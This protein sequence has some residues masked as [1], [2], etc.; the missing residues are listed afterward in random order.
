MQ[1]FV[2]SGEEQIRPAVATAPRVHPLGLQRLQGLQLEVYRLGWARGQ[3][4]CPAGHRFGPVGDDALEPVNP[5]RGGLSRNLG[6]GR[7]MAGTKTQWGVPS[8]EIGRWWRRRKRIREVRSVEKPA[9]GV[10]IFRE[11]WHDDLRVGCAGRP[12]NSSSARGCSNHLVR[13]RPTLPL[14]PDVARAFQDKLRALATRLR[15]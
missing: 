6:I 7:T 9:P 11:E 3:P 8:G 2:E 4:T 5:C 12:A 13:P 1:T 10:R 15:L 14:P